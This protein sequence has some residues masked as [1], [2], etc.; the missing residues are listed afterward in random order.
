M[1]GDYV[2]LLNEELNQELTQDMEVQ[3]MEEIFRDIE[4]N[5][6]VVPFDVIAFRMGVPCSHVVATADKYKD[7]IQ[8]AIADN[9]YYTQTDFGA[10]N[11]ET[12]STVRS[13]TGTSD[14]AG[15]GY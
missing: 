8:N 2:E 10:F 9:P 1:F 15:A 7:A 4:K 14:A 13:A 12:H 3:I 5:G 11:K 6:G